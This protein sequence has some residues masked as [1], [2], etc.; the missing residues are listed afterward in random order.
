MMMKCPLKV[1]LVAGFPR[2]VVFMPSRMVK[3][4]VVFDQIC[5]FLFNSVFQFPPRTTK[6]EVPTT[7]PPTQRTTINHLVDRLPYASASDDVG[8]AHPMSLHCAE[9]HGGRPKFLSWLA[10]FGTPGIFTTWES[11]GCRVGFF[12]GDGKQKKR[13]KI[14][15]RGL[16]WSFTIYPN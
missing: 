14:E 7:I 3:Q 8:A 1:T 5:S 6:T 9:C 4:V 11:M 10:E 2:K 16:K 12:G 15:H 13:S